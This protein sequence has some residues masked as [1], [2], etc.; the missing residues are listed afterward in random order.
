MDKRTRKKDV[1]GTLA[2]L[3]GIARSL[4]DAEVAVA[5][6]QSGSF[7]FLDHLDHPEEDVYTLEDG[8]EA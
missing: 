6:A 3:P 1:S 2:S 5:V 7:N 4:S 8:R